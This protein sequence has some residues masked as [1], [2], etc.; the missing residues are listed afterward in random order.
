MLP[1]SLPSP[2]V[3]RSADSLIRSVTWRYRSH[4]AAALVLN[5]ILLPPN[6]ASSHRGDFE[7][8]TLLGLQGSIVIVKLV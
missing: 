8:S 1:H 2:P 3:L 6:R 4:D 7:I 5:D